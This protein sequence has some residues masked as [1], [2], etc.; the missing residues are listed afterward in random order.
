MRAV[1]M[2]VIFVVFGTEIVTK[3]SQ[4]LIL[5]V[6]MK[7]FPVLKTGQCKYM[8]GCSKYPASIR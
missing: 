1:C 4:K 7:T 5:S 3:S 8:E 6:I 2:L